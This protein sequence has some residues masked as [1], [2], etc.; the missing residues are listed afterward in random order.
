MPADG[1]VHGDRGGSKAHFEL[2]SRFP[3]S[4]ASGDGIDRRQELRKRLLPPNPRTSGNRAPPRDVDTGSKHDRQSDQELK[5][6]ITGAIAR[7]DRRSSPFHQTGS[8]RLSDTLIAEMPEIGSVDRRTELRT[9]RNS[10]RSRTTADPASRETGHR[11]RTPALRHVMFPVGTGRGTHNARPKPFADCLR[12]AEKPQQGR[13]HRR[14]RKLVT[15][16]NALARAV[17][18]DRRDG[19]RERVC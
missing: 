14:R 3:A 8:A 16:A 1:P 4:R 10:P 13:H 11:R 19:Q 5:E 17:R 7:V 15:S 6:R 9:H 12:K 2:A 18:M